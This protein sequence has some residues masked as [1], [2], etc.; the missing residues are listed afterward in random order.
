MRLCERGLDFVQVSNASG[1]VRIC[2]WTTDAIV[3][4]LL[5]SSFEEIW[6]GERANN[7][8]KRLAAGD[9]S[10]CIID[11]CLYLAK[12]EIESNLVQI[13]KL[14]DY[15]EILSLS[16]DN[17]CNYNC[18]TC[19]IHERYH[20]T[21]KA[22][23][24]KQYQI[25]EERLKPV[26]PHIKLL[27]ANGQGEFFAS[28]RLLKM[29]SEWR[30]LAPEKE[31][32]VALE[33]NGSLFD[34]E[35]WH[36]IENIARFNVSAHITV[37]S[38]DEYTYRQL[39]GVNYPVSRIEENLRFVKRLRES[40]AINY[41]ELAT[42]VQERNFRELPEFSRRCI[43]EFGADEVRLRYF[44]PWGKRPLETEW[45]MDVRN[46]YH[47][48][49]QEFLEVMRHPIFKHPKV[50]DWSGG[51]GSLLGEHP[52]KKNWLEA[53]KR[54]EYANQKIKLLKRLSL[55]PKKMME[56]LAGIIPK[57][58]PL[59]IYGMGEIG[60]A[61]FKQME[62]EWNIPYLI[63]RDFPDKAY[64][65]K[66]VCNLD[67]LE[68]K[69]LFEKAIWVLITPMGEKGEIERILCSLGYE[70]EHLIRAGDLWQ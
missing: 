66:D 45:F 12:G 41:I 44:L 15:P 42:V 30:P 32:S 29:I 26:L 62:Y 37:M 54:L 43:E 25:I 22:F 49:H 60:Q 50:N 59:T 33:S 2:T 70:K 36:K 10:K 39:S 46:P 18:I 11:D 56:M 38:F 20:R 51:R 61:L 57:G 40:G 16:Y 6:K 19:N 13:D 7:L 55:S 5:E 58:S 14:P 31:I 24:E 64:E 68:N 4:N 28:A 69:T 34:E 21:D 27:S 63:D 65:G 53:E 47:P 3:G 52:W 8:R 17:L 9:Y 48:Y 23:L 67:E 35:H 1:D